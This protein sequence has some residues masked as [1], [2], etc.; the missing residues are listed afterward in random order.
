MKAAELRGKQ[1]A[2]LDALLGESLRALFKLRMRQ[3][4]GQKANPSE[5]KRLRREIARI[6]TLLHEMKGQET[7]RQEA[8]TG[9]G[10]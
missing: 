1:P 5:F 8:T 3:G 2:E 7:Q 4:S 9:D 10:G 6:K